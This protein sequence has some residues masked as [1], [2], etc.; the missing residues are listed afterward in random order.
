MTAGSV[1]QF[2][3]LAVMNISAA[4]TVAFLRQRVGKA[5]VQEARF[6][7]V[8]TCLRCQA[9]QARGGLISDATLVALPNAGSSVPPNGRWKCSIARGASVR[10]ESQPWI[11]VDWICRSSRLTRL[12]SRLRL[13]ARWR[14]VSALLAGQPCPCRIPVQRPMNWREP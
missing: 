4:T 6:E 12:A 1:E 13:T 14:F 7:M 10:K 11:R 3:G 8:E 2:G 5:A 9:L